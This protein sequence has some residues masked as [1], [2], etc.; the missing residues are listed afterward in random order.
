MTW[1]ARQ[2]RRAALELAAIVLTVVGLATFVLLM[3]FG[4]AHAHDLDC[5]GMPVSEAEKQ[6]CCGAGDA[7][8]SNAEH[9][10]QDERGVWHYLLAGVDYPIVGYGGPIQALPSYDGCYT[11]WYRVAGSDG[12][13]L[14]ENGEIRAGTKPEDVRFYCLEVP[15]PS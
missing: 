5:R 3:M 12:R 4:R 14:A 13:Y 2:G 10:R 11:L 1:A 9:V 6:G 15:M 7:H 8:F